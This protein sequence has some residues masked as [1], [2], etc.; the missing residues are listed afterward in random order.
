MNTI[1]RT[2]RTRTTRILLIVAAVLAAGLFA[3][4]SPALADGHGH[5]K[6]TRSGHVDRGRGPRGPVA[7]YPAVPRVIRVDQRAY[8]QPYYS[9]RTWYA[10]HHH[11]HTVY[12]FPVWVGGSVVY[13]PYDYCGNSV[14]VSGAVTLPHLAFGINFG[15]PGGVSIGGY[16]ASP[17]FAPSPY[18]YVVTPVVPPYFG[19]AFVYA[20]RAHGCDGDCDGD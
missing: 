1:S 20:P 4:P 19:G 6:G 5:G 16:Y 17:G 3:L 9:G 18:P 8:Y 10:P 11:Y 12:R 2:P 15:S 14:F 13:R 7:A